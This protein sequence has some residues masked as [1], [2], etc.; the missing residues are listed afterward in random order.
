M[1]RFQENEVMGHT[2]AK[3]E[4]AYLVFLAAKALK[5]APS[6]LVHGVFQRE[7]C[8]SQYIHPLAIAIHQEVTG[9]RL[10]PPVSPRFAAVS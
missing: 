10:D 2:A 1:T 7:E 4:I 3:R 8:Q 6:C 5:I 9:V